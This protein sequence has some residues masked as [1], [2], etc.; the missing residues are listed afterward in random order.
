[1]PARAFLGWRAKHAVFGDRNRIPRFLSVKRTE[2]YRG[3]GWTGAEATC[4]AGVRAVRRRASN[5]VHALA[6]QVVE[7]LDL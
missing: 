7:Q 6:R 3:V 5:D 4:P 2:Q 1:L